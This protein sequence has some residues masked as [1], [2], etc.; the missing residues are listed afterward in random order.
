MALGF[1]SEVDE[2]QEPI[3]L[4]YSPLKTLKSYQLQYFTIKTHFSKDLKKLFKIKH[5]Q[6]IATAE[7]YELTLK[8]E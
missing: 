5:F 6:Y 7:K 3:K 1:L 4:T 2:P 8:Y